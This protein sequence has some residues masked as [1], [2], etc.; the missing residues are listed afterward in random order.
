MYRE[1]VW[2][3]IFQHNSCAN[4]WLLACCVNEGF[5]TN[6]K[7]HGLQ[8]F[9]VTNEKLL[10]IT[11]VILNISP[12]DKQTEFINQWKLT[13]LYLLQHMYMQ[14]PASVQN[15]QRFI[16][17]PA[18]T[19]NRPLQC[20]GWKDWN[21]HCHWCCPGSAAGWRQSG[22][23]FIL[24]AHQTAKNDAG[25][26]WCK[27]AV[28]CWRLLYNLSFYHCISTQAQYGFAHKAV[29]EHIKFGNTE[30]PVN[31]F[32]RHVQELRYILQ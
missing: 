17:F 12:F 31:H 1:P 16:T 3:L 23:V 25:A 22:S 29:M 19:H 14:F 15:H 18:R 27:T 9:L 6:F 21:F 24:V 10:G 11:E 8:L 7:R 2:V 26:D 20:R 32:K 5:C 30:V 13:Q 28:M 4:V